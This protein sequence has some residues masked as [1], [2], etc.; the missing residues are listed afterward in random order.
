M[1]RDELIEQQAATKE[2]F[3]QVQAELL[4]LQGEHRALQALIDKEAE[5]AKDNATATAKP[6]S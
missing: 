6:K 1:T 5:N 3:E 4:R 2:R